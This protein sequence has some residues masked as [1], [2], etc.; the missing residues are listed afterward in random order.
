[1]PELPEVAL[2]AA[3]LET[4]TKARPLSIEPIFSVGFEKLVRI[5]ET[6]FVGLKGDSVRVETAGKSLFLSIGKNLLEFKFGMTGKFLLEST[7]RDLNNAF[8]RLLPRDGACIYYLDPRRFGHVEISNEESLAEKRALALGG[9][10]DTEFWVRSSTEEIA[11]LITRLF[12]RKVPRKP[13]ISLLLESGVKTGIGNYIANEALGRAELNPFTPFGS[14]DELILT[15]QL[16]AEVAKESFNCGGNSF[17]GGYLR[18]NGKEGSFFDK[19]LF[20]GN[21]L[22]YQ[23]SFRGRPVYSKYLNPGK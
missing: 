22:H 5:T 10:S 2:Y 20:Y 18:L 4:Q 15:L 9:F 7:S 11:S 17:A 14:I 12:P 8:L 3:D 6:D 19:C 16:A 21:Q 13:K 1:M 23:G